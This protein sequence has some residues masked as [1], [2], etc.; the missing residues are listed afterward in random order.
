MKTD[1]VFP[2]G[3]LDALAGDFFG[4]GNRSDLEAQFAFPFQILGFTAALGTHLLFYGARSILRRLRA[5]NLPPPEPR[6]AKSLRGA[7]TPEDLLDAWDAD[8]RTL[9]DRLRIGSRLADLEPTL[10]NRFIFKTNRAGRR[11]IAARQPGLKGWLRKNAP[12]IKYS[13]AMHYKKLATRLRQ[14]V[15]LDAR[16]PVEWLLSSS[17]DGARRIAALPAA[18]RE[19]AAAA[20]AKLRRLLAEHPKYTDLA[21]T[22]E[23]KLGIMRMAT[24]RRIQP[25][26]P[27]RGHRRKPAE[28]PTNPLVSRVRMDGWGASVDPARAEAFWDAV[29]KVLGEQTP[30][31][32]TR[33]LQ[34]DIRAWLN[35]PI[36]ARRNRRR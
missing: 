1:P 8:P 29:R 26:K 32:E 13:T 16:I 30:D 33:R 28:N 24:I 25:P 23:Q 12:D 9:T 5:R 27:G 3:Y 34:S 18:D 6:P 10:D 31:P 35:A 17:E 21:R 22:V 36:Q 11:R 14:L 2:P 20:Q 15:G 4:T 19:A 7:P